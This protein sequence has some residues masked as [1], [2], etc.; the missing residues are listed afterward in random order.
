MPD[1]SAEQL[2]E[3]LAEAL[4]TTAFISL[5]PP[6]DVFSFPE[7]AALYGL[8]FEGAV[9]GELELLAPRE[10]GGLVAANMLGLEPHDPQALE[11]AQDALKELCN[12]T[13]GLLLQ[14]QCGSASPA[15]DMGVPSAVAAC[16]QA[17]RDGFA[18]RPG[19][20][21]AFADGFPLAA[22]VK[23]LP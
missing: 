3:C 21:V 13:V 12:I 23:G 8:R 2:L 1:T 20:V 11:R 9:C 7:S 19:T 22:R 14:R 17:M 16:D 5:E 18:A 6:P 15:P 10:L 4:Q